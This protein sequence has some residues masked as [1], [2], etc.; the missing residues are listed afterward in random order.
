MVFIALT[1]GDVMEMMIMMVMRGIDRC[2]LV[3]GSV[4]R[5]SV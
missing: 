3:G 1:V 2:Y 4:L 5:M